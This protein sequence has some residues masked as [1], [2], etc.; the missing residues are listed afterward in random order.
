MELGVNILD[1]A[2]VYGNGQNEQLLGKA[3]K[4]RREQAVIASKFGVGP[5]FEG[6]HSHPD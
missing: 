5:N 4:G 3:L 2:N 6:I 1:T